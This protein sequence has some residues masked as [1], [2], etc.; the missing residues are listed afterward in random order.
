MSNLTEILKEL[1]AP[2][3][4]YCSGE[5]LHYYENSGSHCICHICE[6]FGK[7]Y[8][9]EQKLFMQSI[10]PYKVYNR[11]IEDLKDRITTLENE[12]Q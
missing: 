6:G 4:Y 9:E 2:P 11:L 7:E 3:C 8:S 10:F 5:G 12:R 1:A